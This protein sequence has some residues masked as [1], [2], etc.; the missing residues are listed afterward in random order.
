MTFV[1]L[2]KT[3][4]HLRSSLTR[5]AFL[6]PPFACCQ[7]PLTGFDSGLLILPIK[8]TGIKP[9]FFIGGGKGNRTPDLLNAI[10][11]LSQL[12][13]TPVIIFKPLHL[14]CSVIGFLI[15]PR[16][17]SAPLLDN[18]TL[19]LVVKTTFRG[20]FHPRAQLSY[21]PVIIS[22]PSHLSC[23][24]IG[25][26]ISPQSLSAPL[27]DNKTLPLVVKTTF[28]GCFHPRALKGEDSRELPYRFSSYCTKKSEC[29]IKKSIFDIFLF[30]LRFQDDIIVDDRAVWIAMRRKKYK[31]LN[32]F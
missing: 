5:P 6:R 11:T 19:P 7:T 9:A 32:D 20:C 13:Y 18:K 2:K 22:K 23:S 27:L 17:L 15:S 24:V 25:F 21:T 30:F 10:Q 8:K 31:A 12:S 14:S 16:S 29:Q 4:S 1:F 28:R 3:R 26:L